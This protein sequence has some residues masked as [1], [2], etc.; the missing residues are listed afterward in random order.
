MEANEVSQ[1]LKKILKVDRTGNYR[2]VRI[3]R[4][5][6]RMMCLPLP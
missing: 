6:E 1:M 2:S 3:T 4:V 5:D